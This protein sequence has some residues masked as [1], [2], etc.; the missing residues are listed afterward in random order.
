LSRGTAPVF[1]H[2]CIAVL[3]H[4]AKAL[5]PNFGSN[6]NR[7]ASLMKHSARGKERK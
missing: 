2:Q 6:I 4:I 7:V 3:E 1:K 5:D